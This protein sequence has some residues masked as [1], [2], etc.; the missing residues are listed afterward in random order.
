MEEE[1]TAEEARRL[2]EAAGEAAALLAAAR[3]EAAAAAERRQREAALAAE[4]A[5]A[6]IQAVTALRVADVRARVLD[7][8]LER[9]FAGAREALCQARIAEDYP[10]ILGRLMLEALGELPPDRAM[11]V[12]CDPRDL[13][14]VNTV[15][16]TVGQR[17][18]VEAS[19]HCWG[20]LLAQDPDGRVVADNT[21]ESRLK[22]ARET[23]WARVAAILLQGAREPSLTTAPGG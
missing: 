12:R 14:L 4:Q 2:E 23:L 11:V 19:L 10:R 22:L 8:L 3:A 7:A 9:V 18:A 21:V 6:E 20:G 13:P 16:G 17:I 5:R 15:A 1:A